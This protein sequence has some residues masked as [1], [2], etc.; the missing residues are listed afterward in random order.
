L[1]FWVALHAAS[2]A[3]CAAEDAISFACSD[4]EEPVPVG[5]IG[6]VGFAMILLLL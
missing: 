1:A 3:F 2:P 6:V 5:R 4:I